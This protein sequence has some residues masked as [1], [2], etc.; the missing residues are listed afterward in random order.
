MKL[1]T[2]YFL[3]TYA[4]SW[5]FFISVAVLSHRTQDISPG[6]TVLQQ[7]LIFLGAITPSLVTLWLLS[8]AGIP[9]QTHALINRIG[10]WEVNIKWYLFAV[11]YIGVIK[12]LVALIYRSITGTWPVFG[13]EAW[14]LM[15]GAIL[16]STW[17]QA[18]E[19]IGWRG[20]ALPRLTEKFGL[21]LATLLLGIIWAFWHLPLFFV[22]GASTFGQSFPLYLLQVIAIS[23]AIGWLY[24]RTQGSLLLTMLMH[25]SINN[26]K[27]IVPSAVLGAT[28]PFTLSSSLVG[29]LTVI[30]L[31]VLA[32]YFLIRMRNVN[33]LE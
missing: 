18:G 15:V 20:F 16:I 24:W 31:W 23:V 10:K 4:V 32:I 8:R 7:I 1:L 21:P 17:V 2:K 28:H 13:Q 3:L 5:T 19:E 14:Y 29:W 6:L 9:G 30:L 33:R 11:G 26:T 12:L 22:K 27:D 25:A